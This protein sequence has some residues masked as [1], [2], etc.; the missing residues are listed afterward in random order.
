MI[1]YWNVTAKKVNELTKGPTDFTVKDLKAGYHAY[2]V[3]GTDGKGTV[4]T[5][6]PVM[7]VVRPALP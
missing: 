6:D 7:V 1:L 5:S 2:S 3:H 4:C